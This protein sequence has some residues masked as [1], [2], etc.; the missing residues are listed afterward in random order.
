M[1]QLL[2]IRKETYMRVLIKEPDSVL[3]IAE[4]EG[5]REINELVGNVDRNG[6][7]LASTGS[8]FRQEVFDNIDMHMNDSAI[9]NVELRNNFWDVRGRNLYCG[10][11]VFAGYD[12]NSSEQYGVCSLTEE[13]ID[14]FRKNIGKI[15]EIDC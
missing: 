15:Y 2:I 11:V 14:Y 1:L 10:T 13:Q 6:E 4:V 12:S 5:L 7:G 9:F 3:R 8:D